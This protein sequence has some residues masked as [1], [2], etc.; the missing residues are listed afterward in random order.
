MDACRQVFRDKRMTARAFFAGV[1]WV[2]LQEQ[3]TSICRLVGCE[4][5]KLD[6]GELTPFK[7]FPKSVDSGL[8]CFL[9]NR[10]T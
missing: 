5:R 4:L 7:L 1:T 3:P 10:V 8:N 6:L 9:R 2:H